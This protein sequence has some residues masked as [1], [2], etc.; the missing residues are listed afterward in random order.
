MTYST[1]CPHADPCVASTRRTRVSREPRVNAGRGRDGFTLVELAVVLVIVG[2]LTGGGLAAFTA[3]AEQRLRREQAQQLAQVRTALYGFAL[4]HGR[5]PCADRDDPPD[6]REDYVGP[7]CAPGADTG[8]LPWATLGVARGDAWGNPLYY[9]V[10]ARPRGSIAD[11]ADAPA[12][13]ADASFG[14]SARANRRI[15]DGAGDTIAQEIPAVV[16]SFGPQ[17]DQVWTRSGFECPGDGRPAAGFS[18]D[19]TANC[20]GDQDFVDAGYRRPRDRAGRFD[21]LVTWLPDTVLKSRM[22]RGGRLP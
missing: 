13:G 14:L 12:S 11:Y 22:V 15:V 20:D 1:L 2:L 16:V 18:A 10:T 8:A 21:D 5:L 19:E 7:D 17:G 9:S 6:G 3:A 4:R